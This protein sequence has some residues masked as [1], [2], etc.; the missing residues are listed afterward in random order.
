MVCKTS[1]AIASA[2]LGGMVWIMINT[3]KNVMNEY[4]RSFDNKQRVIHKAI[5]KNRASIWL[6]GVVLGLIAGLIYLYL[7][8]G[9]GNRDFNGCLFAMIVM[10]VNYFYYMLADKGT[11]MV[12][13]L[14]KDQID[15]HLSVHKM[16][17]TNYHVGMLMGIAGCFFLGRGLSQ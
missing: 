10:G 11:Y 5:V 4:E 9:T 2:F 7:V 12:E 16:M 1:C 14:R 8:N 17:Q 6:Q 13:H 15:E 3:D